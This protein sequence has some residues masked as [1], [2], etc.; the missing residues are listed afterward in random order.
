MRFHKIFEEILIE[1]KRKYY[2]LT[3]IYL[4]HRDLNQRYW[5]LGLKTAT[6]RDIKRAIHAEMMDARYLRRIIKRGEK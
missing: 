1:M 6:K 3:A 5:S 2:K 4:L